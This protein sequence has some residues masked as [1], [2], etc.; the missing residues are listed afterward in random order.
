MTRQSG[1][2][3][4]PRAISPER[5]ARERPVPGIGNDRFS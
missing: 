4:M 1:Q 5:R 3:G 2:P